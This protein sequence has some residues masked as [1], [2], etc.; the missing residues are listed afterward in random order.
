MTAETTPAPPSR[1]PDDP[2][3][4]GLR[5]MGAASGAAFAI[6]LLLTIL[7]SGGDTPDWDAPAE[8]WAGYA[9]DNEADARLAGITMG[10]GAYAFIFFLGFLRS[11]LGRRETLARGFT[12]LSFIAFAGGIV[13]IAGLAAGIFL[14]AAALAHSQDADPQLVRGLNQLSIA[15]FGVASAGL[16][17]FGVATGILGLTARVLPAWLG[18]VAL[19]TGV[20]F[21]LT[22]GTFLS[23]RYD[24]AFG[25]FYP[26]GFLGLVV[27][28]VG[29]GAEMLRGVRAP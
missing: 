19:A 22:F 23:E 26:L 29:A 3:S 1:D 21:L 7:L 18:A 15:G 4:A 20:C 10:L 17:P 24:N 6:L 12:R 8:Q 27:F 9:R 2:V 14:N 13:G 25:A 5:R 11:E 16:A 28:S